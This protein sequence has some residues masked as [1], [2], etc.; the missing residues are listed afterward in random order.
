[1][2]VLKYEQYA[3]RIRR[4]NSEKNRWIDKEGIAGP[5]WVTC[6]TEMGVTLSHI[7]SHWVIYPVPRYESEK[8]DSPAGVYKG[9]QFY[10][11]RLFPPCLSGSLK[12]F[13]CVCIYCCVILKPAA[14]TDT[15]CRLPNSAERTADLPFRLPPPCLVVFVWLSRI[16]KP[17]VF[18][19]QTLNKAICWRTTNTWY[20]SNKRRFQRI[21]GETIFHCTSLEPTARGK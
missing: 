12:K 18:H 8:D 13:T 15:S 1:M 4:A 19:R 17:W 14:D 2:F 21:L 7:E 16:Y 6:G 11:S 10:S 20:L 3:W 9:P 5:E